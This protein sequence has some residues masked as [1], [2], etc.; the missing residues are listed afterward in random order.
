MNE[1]TS[2]IKSID[3][4]EV[5]SE[6][7]E[8]KNRGVNH[9]GLCPFHTEKTPSFTVS[10]KKNRYQCF[11]C[12][13]GGDVADFIQEYEGVEMTEA[14]KILDLGDYTIKPERIAQYQKPKRINFIPLKTMKATL[15]HYENNNF[16]VFLNRL[17]E[18]NLV[19]EITTNI[20]HVGTSSSL[21]KGATVFWQM[22]A[23][24]NLREAKIMLYDPLTGKRI[25][26]EQEPKKGRAKVSY[27]GKR[28]LK[29]MG[30]QE[31]NLK[32]C[33]FG[34]HQLNDT[35][36]PIAIVESEKTA[37]LM[38]AFTIMKK[39]PN[40]TWIAT[41]GKTGINLK[42]P[43]NTSIL[44]GRKVLLFP[45]LNGYEE[46]EEYANHLN[47]CDVSVSNVLR[48][49]CA[50]EDKEK[51]LDIADFF[52][53]TFIEEEPPEKKPTVKPLFNTEHWDVLSYYLPWTEED[54]QL[55]EKEVKVWTKEIAELR[56]FFAST[57]LD[58]EIK[59][60]GRFSISDVPQFIESH[61]SI[62]EMNN[63]KEGFL[64]YL[65]RLRKVRAI[66]EGAN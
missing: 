58:M 60:D 50:P 38:T 36:K 37:I 41:G 42:Y 52:L 28:I 6:Y 29:K 59:L 43:N 65:E 62:V 35:T 46:W 4:V 19:K 30:I 22:D 44:S 7:V 2:K 34:E 63:G 51:G 10:E 14:L 33:F 39:A 47:N 49:N 61:L 17:F 57:S 8:L 12:G 1:L 45:D 11:G 56:A 18:P 3:I 23:S 55:F 5:I 48:D 54:E 9:I 16:V 53:D 24:S 20:F 13:K 15:R 32:L 31:P 26:K 66:I 64:P 25:K 21:W 40:Y 27:I